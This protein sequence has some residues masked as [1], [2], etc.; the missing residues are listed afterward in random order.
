MNIREATGTDLEDVLSVEREAFGED[1]EAGLVRNLLDDPT[2]LPLLSLVA[3]DGDRA[4]GHVLFTTAF[5]ADDPAARVAILAPLAVVPAAQKQGVGTRLVRS[6]LELI[7]AW[8]VDLVFVLGDP[9]YY[10]RH[11]FEPARPLGFEAPYPIPEEDAD[12]WMVQALKP[13]A[14]G[15]LQGKVVCADALDRPEYWRE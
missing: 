10:P 5:L 7:S 2:A 1:D 13:G 4:V 3:F 6:G 8:G 12:A 15:S 14:I 11:G 9:R